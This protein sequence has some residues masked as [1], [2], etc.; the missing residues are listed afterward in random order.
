MEDFTSQKA[1]MKSQT[2]FVLTDKE[3][4]SLINDFLIIQSN[5]FLSDNKSIHLKLSIDMVTPARSLRVVSS[6]KKFG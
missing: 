1:D 6:C 3:G 4:R 2:D 5:W